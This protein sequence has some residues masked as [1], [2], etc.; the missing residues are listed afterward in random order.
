MDSDRPLPIAFC[1]TDLDPGGAERALLQIVTRLER[2]Q[3]SPHVFCLSGEGELAGPLRAA[4]VPVECL[5]IRRWWPCGAVSRLTRR[6]RQLQPQVLQTFLHHANIAGRWAGRRAK[7][8]VIVS[9]VRVAERRSRFR[10]WLDRITGRWVDRHVCVSQGVAEFSVQTGGLPRDK[11]VVIPNGVDVERF[12]NAAPADLSE[13]GI[14]PE[15]KTILSVGRLDPQKGVMFLLQAFTALAQS[16]DDVHLL[17]VGSGPLQREIQRF[18]GENELQ[19]RVHLAGYRDDVPAV[20]R[21][22]DCLALASLWEG[23]P[24]VILEAMAAALPVVSTAVEGTAELLRDGETGRLVPPGDAAAL[25]TS[26][27]ATLDSP[28]DSHEMAQAA[29]DFVTKSFTWGRIVGNYAR[30]YRELIALKS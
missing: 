30:L 9:G 3:W 19:E 4:G 5:R 29:Q 16:R 22:C 11:I 28:G 1:I 2:S 27:E 20:M 26:L 15:H 18:A 17:L 6:L 14:P 12:R 21:A 13:F 8:P 24:N 7:V 23:M 25:Q 10:L